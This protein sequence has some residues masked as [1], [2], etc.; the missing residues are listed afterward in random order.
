MLRITFDM[1]TSQYR[2]NT[3]VSDD[4]RGKSDG[5][6]HVLDIFSSTEKNSA[7]APGSICQRIFLFLNTSSLPLYRMIRVVSQLKALT[8]GYLMMSR[9][10]FYDNWM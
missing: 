1:L 2:L 7:L 10:Q 5:G 6:D 8:Q 3:V 9:L 4:N